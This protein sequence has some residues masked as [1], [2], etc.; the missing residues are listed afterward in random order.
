VLNGI[1]EMVLQGNTQPDNPETYKKQ[2][3]GVTVCT[4]GKG[5]LCIF[6]C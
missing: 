3:V 4:L 6:N 1:K 2:S 5:C